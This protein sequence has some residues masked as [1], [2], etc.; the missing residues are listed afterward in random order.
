MNVSRPRLVWIIAAAVAL[1]AAAIAAVLLTRDAPAAEVAPSPSATPAEAATTPSVTPSPSASPDPDYGMIVA[2][3]A[4]DD[5]A[6]Y[7]AAGGS[8]TMTLDRFSE[9]A[10]QPLTL[11]GI[12]T[13]SVD[14]VDWIQVKLPVQ[15]NGS[16]GWIRADDVT[17]T[18]TDIEIR[19]YLAEHEL[20]LLDDGGVV[21]TTPVAVGAPESPTPPGV[22]YVTDPLDFTHNDTGVY[23]AYALGLSGFS[24]VL[25]E[26]YGGPPQLAIHGTNQPQLIGQ[27]VSNGCIRL[28][29]DAVIELAGLVDLG[30]PVVI[31]DSRDAPLPTLG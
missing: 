31:L 1:V 6:V 8:Q 29:N 26:F 2:T 3:T 25:E 11:L 18:S 19:I 23:G 22:Y 4:V 15:P 24:E 20:E 12:A 10:F 28:P 9:A 13:T 14:G 17:V 21:L 16:T 7:D 5:L 30:T 27:S